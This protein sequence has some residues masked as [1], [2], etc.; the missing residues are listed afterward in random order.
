MGYKFSI[1]FAHLIMRLVTRM[2]VIGFENVP[3]SGN[4]VI[5]SNH[6]GRLDPIMVYTILQREDIIMFVAEK[7]QKSAV[8]RWFVRWLDAI[9]IDRFGAFVV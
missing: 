6:L 3:T 7:Y 2:N 4:F 9:F 5:A 1:F 8:V